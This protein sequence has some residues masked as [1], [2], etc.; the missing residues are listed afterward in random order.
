MS[1]IK[2]RKCN[3]VVTDNA[4]KERL[5]AE[6]AN[7]IADGMKRVV[8]VASNFLPHFAAKEVQSAAGCNDVLGKTRSINYKTWNEKMNDGSF[9]KWSTR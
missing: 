5:A 9:R 6:G 4:A 3:A 7:R 1:G 8:N 2:C